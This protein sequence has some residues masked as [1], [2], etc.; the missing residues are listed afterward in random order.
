MEEKLT[1]RETTLKNGLRYPSDEELIMLILGTGTKKTSLR[2]LSQKVIAVINKA[3]SDDCVKPLLK[4][5]GIGM[6]K[7]LSIAAALE[8]GRRRMSV[9]GVKIKCPQDLIPYV[10]YITMENQ[11]YFLCATL[12]G[13]NEILKIRTVSAGASNKALISAREI[14]S[15]AIRDNASAVLFCHNH[16]SGNKYPSE[17]DIETTKRLIDASKI[18]GITILDHIILT[19]NSYYSFMEHGILFKEVQALEKSSNV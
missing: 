7:A 4:I 10:K 8:L 12:N 1:I 9:L 3:G 17:Q 19:R 5:N 16:P 15:N 18:L 6:T 13:A 2:E 14:F 11:E